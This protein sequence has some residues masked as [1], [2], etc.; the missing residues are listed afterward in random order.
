MAFELIF[1]TGFATRKEPYY[2]ISI[3][4][5]LLASRYSRERNKLLFLTNK[6]IFQNKFIQDSLKSASASGNSEDSFVLLAIPL[7]L[8]ISSAFTSLTS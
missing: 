8:L 6:S 2:L 1:Q 5:R 7:L 3:S 4:A